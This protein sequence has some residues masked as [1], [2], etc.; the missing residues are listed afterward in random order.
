VTAATERAPPF[1]NA[2]AQ[3]ESVHA[4]GAWE[5][6]PFYNVERR[7]NWYDFGF[8]LGAGSPLLGV[9]GRETRDHES[10]VGNP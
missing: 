3:A 9:F 10:N 4:F 6:F 2:A 5:R 8:L 7:G 1:L